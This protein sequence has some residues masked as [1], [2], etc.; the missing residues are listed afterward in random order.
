MSEQCSKCGAHGFYL[1]LDPDER[2]CLDCWKSIAEKAEAERDELKAEVERL[3][4]ESQEQ[5]E[6]LILAS[7][8]NTKLNYKI[9][10]L[11][12][13]VD[14]LAKDASMLRRPKIMMHALKETIPIGHEVRIKG[15]KPVSTYNLINYMVDVIDKVEMGE[16]LPEVIGFEQTRRS[17]NG[18]P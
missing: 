8:E 3:T 6:A 17:S 4:K 15:S 14:R 10:S 12:E 13:D 7:G 2:I 16:F 18:N 1:D 5:V 9:E 11:S